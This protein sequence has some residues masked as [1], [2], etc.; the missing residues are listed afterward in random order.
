MISVAWVGGAK[1]IRTEV[2]GSADL[3]GT[4]EPSFRA[5]LPISAVGGMRAVGAGSR[6]A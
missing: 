3:G 1:S 6:A 5:A 4:P 2:G